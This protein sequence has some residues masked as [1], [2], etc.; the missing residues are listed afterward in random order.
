[1]TLSAV[2]GSEDW[3]EAFPV[4]RNTDIRPENNEG[5]VNLDVC[6]LSY[7][8]LSSQYIDLSDTTI[9][10]IEEAAMCCHLRDFPAGLQIL[11][12]LP[13]ELSRHPA[14]VYERSELLWHNWSLTS[15]E[16]FLEES[17]AWAK[18]HVPNS[19]KY[20]I[21]TLLRLALGRI[22]AYTMGNFTEARDAIREVKAWLLHVPVKEYTD[23][24]VNLYLI[25]I[26]KGH[27][28]KTR[29]ASPTASA[30]TIVFC[31]S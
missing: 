4:T 8:S 7:G 29:P 23:V 13:V 27:S 31:A 20:G 14:V 22:K 10:Q 21:Y 1:M 28:A 5:N 11:D 17:L 18:E 3:N 9:V 15:C 19:G 30:I 12:S 24:Q 25:P 16:E 6:R 2:S 26:S